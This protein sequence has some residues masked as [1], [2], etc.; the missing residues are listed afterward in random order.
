MPHAFYKA[1][2]ENT[3]IEVCTRS[4]DKLTAFKHFARL[5][6]ITNRAFDLLHKH[7][8]EENLPA[9]WSVW[10]TKHPFLRHAVKTHA[11][12]RGV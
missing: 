12:L 9:R 2:S 3:Q 8:F 11:H 5:V 1:D 6:E 4:T 10:F 7:K